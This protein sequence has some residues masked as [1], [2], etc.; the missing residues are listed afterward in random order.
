MQRFKMNDGYACHVD[1]GGPIVVEN[2][3]SS[4]VVGVVS[5]IPIINVMLSWPPP[6]YCNCEDLPEVHARVR[7]VVPWIKQEMDKKKLAFSCT[8]D[9]N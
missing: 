5:K 1:S 6:C 9:G 7:I 3:G 4:V 8:R 2:E